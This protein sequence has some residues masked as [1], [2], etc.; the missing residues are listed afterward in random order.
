MFKNILIVVG[1]VA[2]LFA[3]YAFLIPMLQKSA[4]P[5]ELP[6]EMPESVYCTADAM[7]C[8]DGSYVGRVGPTCN[9]AACPGQ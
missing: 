8:P 6:S 9:F 7:E 4:T 5:S 1:G 2:A 3:V